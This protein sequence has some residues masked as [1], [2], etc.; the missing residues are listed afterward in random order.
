VAKPARPFHPTIATANALRSGTVVFRAPDG[1]WTR[2]L[3]S[4]AIAATPDAAATL[5]AEA[6]RDQDAC[7]IVDPVLVEIQRDGAVIRPGSLR[8][9]IRAGGPTITIPTN[10]RG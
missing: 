2:D 6:M 1:S 4:A 3:A 7:K 5:L 9:A 8:E 10:A